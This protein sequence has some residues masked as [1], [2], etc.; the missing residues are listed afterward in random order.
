MVEQDK[1]KL[2]PCPF[3]GSDMGRFAGMTP[4]AFAKGESSDG[5]A[6]KT[7][8]VC[9]ECG[10]IGPD[11]ETMEQAVGEWNSRAEGG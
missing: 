7:F 6:L 11:G 10:A 4:D 3:C 8:A 9:C 5:T 2:E 1:P